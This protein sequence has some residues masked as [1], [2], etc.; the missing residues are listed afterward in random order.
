MTALLR[1]RS[2]NAAQTAVFLVLIGDSGSLR[3][4][5]IRRFALRRAFETDSLS[6]GTRTRFCRSKRRY[7]RQG[8]K[9]VKTTHI[10]ITLFILLVP[11]LC[12]AASA[13]T[14]ADLRLAGFYASGLPSPVEAGRRVATPGKMSLLLHH[15]QTNARY[16][17]AVDSDVSSSRIVSERCV[18]LRSGED[19]ARRVAELHP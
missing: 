10:I 9:P 15:L 1:S 14:L 4:H 2:L 5:L 12:S 13:W 11:G 7:S 18:R 17:C 3:R 19:P 8:L 16:V 6:R